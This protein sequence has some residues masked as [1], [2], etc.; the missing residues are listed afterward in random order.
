[1]GRLKQVSLLTPLVNELN[2]KERAARDRPARSFNAS[3]L[4]DCTRQQVYSLLGYKGL[5]SEGDEQAGYHRTAEAG[6]ALH[7]RYQGYLRRSNV[8]LTKD[9]L[10]G[11]TG[12][13]E[14]DFNPIYLEKTGGELPWFAE[15][16]PLPRNDYLI[17][18]R[19]DL[20]VDIDGP[21]IVEIKTVDQRK[22]DDPPDYKMKAYKAQAA[23]YMH[24]SGIHRSVIWMVSR[25]NEIPKEYYYEYDE[26]DVNKFLTRIGAA[27]SHYDRGEIPPAEPGYHCRF[28]PF[29]NYCEFDA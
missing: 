12:W 18:G 11:V 14:G 21:L 7:D 3:K 5:P 10:L 1:M 22:Y 27:K 24:F 29:I 13:Q 4:T 8:V 17:G 20:V 23:A 25:N 26:E 2:L 6:N 16:F 28:C 9:Q 19:I 15:E